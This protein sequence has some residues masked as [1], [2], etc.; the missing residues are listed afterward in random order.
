MTHK[1]I[2][3]KQYN[4]LK[5]LLAYYGGDRQLMAKGLGV[6]DNV[7]YVWFTRGR[8]SARKAILAHQITNGQ[9]TRQSLR[10]D[11]LAWKLDND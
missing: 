11:V 1:E 5:A 4:G 10:P 6:S 3:E 9:I 7:V 8:I 2:E